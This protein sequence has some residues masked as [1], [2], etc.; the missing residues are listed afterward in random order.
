MAHNTYPAVDEQKVSARLGGFYSWESAQVE[1]VTLPD[2]YQCDGCE[3]VLG[4]LIRDSETE[5]TVLLVNPDSL[6]KRLG[7]LIPKM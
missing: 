7:E 3:P 4:I 5:D 2:E 6:V 1:L